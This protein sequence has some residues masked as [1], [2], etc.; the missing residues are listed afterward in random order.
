MKSLLNPG[1]TV[2]IIY[3]KFELVTRLIFQ[4]GG[5]PADSLTPSLFFYTGSVFGLFRIFNPFFF[6]ENAVLRDGM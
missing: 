5:A 3:G 6:K 1:Y 2:V 4:Y